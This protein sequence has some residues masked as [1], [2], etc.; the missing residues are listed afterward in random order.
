MSEILLGRL[1]GPSGFER[2]VVLKRILP[3]LARKPSFTDMF[4]DEARIVAGIRHPNVVHVHEMGRDGD[5]LYLVLE[6]LEGESVASILRR[7]SARGM[8][9][10]PVVGAHIVAEACAGLHAAHELKNAGGESLDIVH[11]DV[12]PQNLF[13]TYEG[14]VKLLDFGIAKAADRST[15]TETGTIKGKFAYMS[16][17]QCRAETLDR[18]SDV[19]A[20]GVVLYELT[21][22]R[23]LF[24]RGSP[25]LTF[26]A[27]CEEPIPAPSVT[28]A[29]YPS[30]LE[31]IC[32]RCLARR[33]VDRYQTAHELRRDLLKIVHS[34]D[35]DTTPDEEV[36]RLLQ[37]LFSERISEKR[38]LLKE[39]QSG[40]S[41]KYIPAVEIDEDVEV[42]TVGTDAQLKT[43]SDVEWTRPR[44]RPWWLIAAAALA[45]GAGAVTLAR[46][47]SDPGAA[48]AGSALA[49][50]S[51]TSAKSAP[52]TTT[53]QTAV[54]AAPPAS[55][56]LG[57]VP[58]ASQTQPRGERTRADRARRAPTKPA[59]AAP[60]ATAPAPPAPSPSTSARKPWRFE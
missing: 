7:A 56:K 8:K 55:V 16:P 2:L 6:Y 52:T 53:P 32:M 1:A 50:A 46:L 13:I 11:R 43:T 14:A 31:R 38:M 12:S 9:L 20:L 47:R 24:A 22:G 4:L 19:F 41:P 18:R 44:H 23:R 15:R 37:T 33:R 59:P 40:A 17:E 26:K 34:A 54:S 60:S 51:A 39:V 3:H 49:P 45:V 25:P 28:V 36:A 5:E 57:A 29:D 48:T 58:A 10:D 35:R 21:V 30:E 27:I 42:P